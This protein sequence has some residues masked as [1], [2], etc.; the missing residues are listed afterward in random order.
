MNE[1][2]RP[3]IGRPAGSTQ[4]HRQ[5]RALATRRAIL[6]ASSA[7]FDIEGYTAARLDK[8]LSDSNLS[9]GALYFHFPSKE[10]IA[11]QLIADWDLAV[12]EAFPQQR[13]PKGQ[14]SRN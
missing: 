3:P 12:G 6:A 2:V 7:N 9:K 14:P 11:Q 8:I 13:P 1:V 10:A 5:S 4:S